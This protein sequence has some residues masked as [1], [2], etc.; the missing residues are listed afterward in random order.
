[1]LSGDID[2]G[3]APQVGLV[4]T[5]EVLV[6]GVDM[7]AISFLVGLNIIVFAVIGFRFGIGFHF[8][9]LRFALAPVDPLYGF[10]GQYFMHGF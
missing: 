10:V 5:F 4:F 3:V 1:V 9:F 6:P 8:R 7:S 2:A